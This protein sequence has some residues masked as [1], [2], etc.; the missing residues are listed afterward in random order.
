MSLF[1]RFRSRLSI[2]VLTPF[3]TLLC[4]VSV[5]RVSIP[6]TLPKG[7]LRY[8]Y[9]SDVSPSLVYF[10]HQHVLRFPFLRR[11]ISLVVHV[12]PFVTLL[13][14][15][16]EECLTPYRP[17]LS[18]YLLHHVPLRSLDSVWDLDFLPVLLRPYCHPLK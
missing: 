2:H 7:L 13:Y 11:T 12:I 1:T 9:Y 16:L 10:P 15:N 6:R 17:H 8:R 14:R 5:D 3:T 4:V 18:R